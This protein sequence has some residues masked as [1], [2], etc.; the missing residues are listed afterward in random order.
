MWCRDRPSRQGDLLRKAVRGYSQARKKAQKKRGPCKIHLQVRVIPVKMTKP[1][2]L[3][4]SGMHTHSAI[5]VFRQANCSI[6]QRTISL[7]INA[8]LE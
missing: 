6:Q 4:H 3:V 7:K 5:H 8:N 2:L 1:Y